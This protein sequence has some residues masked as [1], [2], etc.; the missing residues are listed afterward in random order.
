MF[1]IFAGTAGWE[2]CMFFIFAGG[3]MYV[4][5]FRGAGWP[6]TCMFFIFAG[7]VGGETCMFFIFA[8]GET[9]MF[10]SRQPAGRIPMQFLYYGPERRLGDSLHWKPEGLMFVPNTSYS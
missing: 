10:F 5:Y 6:E 2:T 7:T 1:F 3:D 8:D 4:F 9:C